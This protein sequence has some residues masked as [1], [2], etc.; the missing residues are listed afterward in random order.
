MEYCYEPDPLKI[1][2]ELEKDQQKALHYLKESDQLVL[3]WAQD[4]AILEEMLNG[5]K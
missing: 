5:M 2:E 1:K 3:Q 4:D